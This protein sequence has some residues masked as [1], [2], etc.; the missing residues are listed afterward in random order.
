MR[1]KLD[2]RVSPPKSMNPFKVPARTKPGDIWELGRH[3][4]MC[5][6]STDSAHVSKLMKNRRADVC[7]TSPPY[8]QQRDYSPAVKKKVANWDTLM[9]GVF[10]NL[11]MTE[12]GQ[13][14][15]NLGLIHR[16]GEWQ[17]YWNNW[18]DFMAKDGWRRFGWY[19]WDQGPGL[20]GDWR[21]R[22][23]PS[24]E[25]VFH[26]NRISV[27]PVKFIPCKYAGT[28]KTGGGLRNRDGSPAKYTHAG[29]AIQD[30]KIPDSVIRLS[31]QK[32][33][34]IETNHPA[35]FPIRLAEFGLRCWPGLAYE[36]FAGSGTTIIAAERLG[37]SCYAMELNAEFVDIILARW[38]TETGLTA[39][40][41][42]RA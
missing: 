13:V 24:H 26:F 19:V 7:F 41:M 23:A 2:A 25:F 5:G 33:R 28:P 30:T 1:S 11:P 21:G 17:P 37:H 12:K 32:T 10:R 20:P 22:L 31:R 16:N 38:E 42:E 9:R 3:R 18:L 29:R 6:D 8:G 15:V 4:I 35:V 27:K 36:P 14:L 39:E 40:V 34:G